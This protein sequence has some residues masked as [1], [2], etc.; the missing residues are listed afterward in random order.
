[1]RKVAL[2]G[3]GVAKFGV[4]QA[5]YR[6]L[7]WE[8]G[9]AC[10]DS[11]PAIRPRDVEGLVVGSVMP[12][13]TAFQSHISSMAAE[14]LG[15]KPSALSARTEHMC[16]S[17]TVGIRYAY[18]FIAA[19]LADLVMVLGVEKLNQPTGQEAI[20]NMGTGVDREWEASFGLTAPPCFAL[21]A[22]RHMAEYGTTEAQLAAV[23]VKNHNHAAKNPNAHFSKGA[24]VEQ[25]LGSRMISSPLRL[26]MCSPITDGAAA[27]ILASE[28][29]ARGLTDAPVW[30]RGTGQALDG[31]TLSSLPEN[32]ARWP[33]LV[34]A[35]ESAYRMAGI[36]A[37]EVE[38]AEVHDCF[39]IAEIIA[40]EE[41]GF[42]GKGE[43][44][45]FAAAGRSDHGGDVV[46]N[47][48]GGL[49][50]CGHP[51]GATGVAQAAEIFAQLRGE[52]GPRQVPRARIG[53][54]HN[55]SGMGEHVVMIYGREAA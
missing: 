40:T 30:I 25:V 9:K 44:G 49:I 35:A 27:V 28:D 7:I 33:S 39:T 48:R 51:L 45:P 29:R 14:A 54:T 3:A 2:V 32:Y 43:G 42:C 37:R 16:A 23:G 38:V 55:N 15:I 11:V 19:G 41:L 13:R 46:V 47:P 22:Q 21:A 6:D 52:A 18:A 31:F 53:L 26:F 50:G 8:A 10:F 34:R 1:M 17:G 12:E 24:T 36:T 4:R 5:S 20:L